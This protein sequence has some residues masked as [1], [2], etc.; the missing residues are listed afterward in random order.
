MTS[1]TFHREANPCGRI[2]CIGKNYTEHIR[3]LSGVVPEEPVVF[4]KPWS[5]L[6]APEETVKIPRHGSQ[7][8]HEVEVVF[9]IGA[10]G[11]GIPESEAFD[12][13]DGVTLG[14]DLTLR[15]VQSR[16][17]KSGYPWELAK[18]FEQSAP[19]GE[20]VPLQKIRDPQN[21]DFSCSVNG[22]VRQ[23]GN[24]AEMIF[25]LPKLVSFLSSVWCLRPGDLIF[26]GTP[27]GVGILGSGDSA[28]I[29][30]PEIGEFSWQFK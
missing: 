4:I 20:Y 24:T 28:T 21:L 10:E 27:S 26:T 15:D 12:Y 14:L 13:I 3:E 6:V 19:L 29:A 7:L 2:F 9:K 8:H 30:S 18:A 25:S 11:Q 22:Q 16:L 23:K 17:K 1:S 5:S